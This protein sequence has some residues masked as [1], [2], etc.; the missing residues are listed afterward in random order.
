MVHLMGDLERVLFLFLGSLV[1]LAFDLARSLSD[2][3]VGLVARVLLL[4]SVSGCGG[5]ILKTACGSAIGP[6]LSS[7]LLLFCRSQLTPADISRAFSF[8]GWLVG[9]GQVSPG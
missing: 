4:S 6:C 1:L 9:F 8:S 7:A 3:M 5:V 2:G